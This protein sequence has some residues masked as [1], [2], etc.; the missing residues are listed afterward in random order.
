M[1][2]P[3][4]FHSE[5]PLLNRVLLRLS[6]MGCMA[7]KNATG[8]GRALQEPHPVVRYGLKGSTDII[9]VVPPHGRFLGVEIKTKNDRQSPA[10]KSFQKAIERVGGVYVIVRHPDEVEALVEQLRERGR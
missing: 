4:E 8:V 5:A 7:W 3:T 6:A 1:T 10:Q 9:A 2:T